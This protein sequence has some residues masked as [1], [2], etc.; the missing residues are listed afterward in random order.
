VTIIST[1]M[2]FMLIETTIMN[3]G[4][5]SHH[6]GLCSILSLPTIGWSS[7]DNK[8]TGL[9]VVYFHI[10]DCIEHLIINEML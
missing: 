5:L 8:Q 10:P 3:L 1:S 7:L 6:V 4:A 9:L 2:L